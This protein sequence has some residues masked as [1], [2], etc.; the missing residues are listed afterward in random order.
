MTQDDRPLEG[1]TVFFL[2]AEDWSF[3][4]HRLPMARAARDA[5]ATVI[6]GVRF[7]GNGHVEKIEAEGFKAVSIPFDRSGINPVKDWVTLL[8]IRKAFKQYKPDL[9]HNVAMKPVLYGSLAAWITGVPAVVNA[10]T[11]LGYL[12]ISQSLKAKI[13]RPIVKSLLKWLNNRDGT[14]LLLQNQDDQ[15]TFIQDIEVE[16]SHTRIIRGSG[17]DISQYDVTPE[18]EGPIIAT[19]VARMLKDKGIGELVEA[20]R[21]LKKYGTDIRIRLVGP[22]DDNPASFSQAE[23]DSWAAEGIVEVTGPSTD[24][25]GEYAKSHIAVLPSYRE[26]LPK[27]LLE[28][29]ACGRAL[30]ATDVPGCREICVDGKTGILVPLKSIE[31]L[32]DALQL[33]AEKPE[34]RQRMAKEA[35][36]AVETQF[37]DSIIQRQIVQLY[38]ALI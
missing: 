1:K 7:N 37:S 21:L 10:M 29:A 13:L 28:G 34:I 36:K 23:L 31:P 20:A 22:T 27:S 30:I 6:A 19:C 24:I 26:G 3:C 2:A 38:D 33:L 25:A 15:R 4:S 11:G 17:V 14:R 9:I 32:A 35:R 8:A 16:A 5:G 18:P 12:F